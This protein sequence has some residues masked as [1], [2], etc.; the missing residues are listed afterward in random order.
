MIEARGRLS[1]LSGHERE[2]LDWL[3]RGSSNKNIARELDISPRTVE[4]H[5]ANMMS[6]LGANHA[7]DAVRLRLEAQLEDVQEA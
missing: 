1:A 6:K 7:A 2:V 3:S 5:R 4:I